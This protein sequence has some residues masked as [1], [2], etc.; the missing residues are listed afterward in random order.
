MLSVCR[1]GHIVPFRLQEYTTYSGGK[2]RLGLGFASPAASLSSSRLA[3]SPAALQRR[4]WRLR[5]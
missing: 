5:P 3:N 1:D 4:R 2:Q